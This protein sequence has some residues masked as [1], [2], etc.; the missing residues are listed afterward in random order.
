MPVVMVN[1]EQLGDSKSPKPQNDDGI[2]GTT[3]C[4]AR[5]KLCLCFGFQRLKAL[6]LGSSVFRHRNYFSVLS[7]RGDDTTSFRGWRTEGNE[8]G[9]GEG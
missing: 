6:N 9:L 1:G 7:N 8:M 3:A 2:D 4:E 5:M